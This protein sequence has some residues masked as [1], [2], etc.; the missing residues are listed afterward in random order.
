[1]LLANANDQTGVLTDEGSSKAF[2]LEG[3]LDQ[4]KTQIFEAL[5]NQK[6]DIVLTAHP[7]EVNR[8]TLLRK[9]RTISEILASLDRMDFTYY[10][11]SQAVDSLRRE[12]GSIWGSDEIRRV[13]PTPQQESGGGIAIL[14]SVIWDA[15][16]SYLRKLNDQCLQSL[17]R[18]LPLDH[19]PIS[20][21]SWM[22]GDR[23][24]NPNVTPQVTHEVATMQRMQAARLL[25]ADLDKLYSEIAICKGFSSE[26]LDLAREV[27]NSADKRELYRRVIGHLRLRLHATIEWCAAELNGPGLGRSLVPDGENENT[28]IMGHPS[29]PLFDQKD[30]FIPLK[31]M[32]ESLCEGGYSDVADGYLVD[33]IRR[34]ATFGLTLVPLGTWVSPFIF[35]FNLC[36]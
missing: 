11:R 33:V 22:G 13:K 17:Q 34:V 8:R 6:V 36:K 1:M 16:P 24:G 35:W 32:H 28:P 23:D 30:I 31:I 18:K 12:V 19:V 10:E 20:F 27:K 29:S 7:T 14:E 3:T 5:L 15:V 4:K 2:D 21:S 9:Y 25:L 26:M